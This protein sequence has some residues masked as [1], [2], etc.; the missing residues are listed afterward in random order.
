[1]GSGSELG[2]G[3]IRRHSGLAGFSKKPAALHIFWAT[4]TY[5][6][7]T[8]HLSVAV[9]VGVEEGLGAGVGL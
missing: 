3:F 2:L 7:L 4:G 5:A 8:V 1:M 9:E 6:V